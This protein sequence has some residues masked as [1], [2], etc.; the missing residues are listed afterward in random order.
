MQKGTCHL[1]QQKAELKHSHILPAFVFRW[2]KESAGNGHIRHGMEPNKRIQD[3]LKR[4]WLCSSCEDLLNLSE[5]AFATN[6]FHPY[7]EASGK[8]FNYTRWLLPFCVSLSWRV[9]KFYLDETHLNNWDS[10]SLAHVVKAEKVWREFLLEE[11]PHPGS[12]Q[13]HILPLDQIA[14]ATGEL[15]P[16]INRYLMRAVDMDICKGGKTIFTYTKLGRFIVLGFV[17]EPNPNNWRSTKVNANKGLVGPKKYILPRSFWDYLDQKA[18]RMDELLNSVSDKQQSKI[19]GA[20]RKNID[21]YLESDAHQAMLA[22]LSMFG[23]AAFSKRDN[24]KN[25]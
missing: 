12:Y 16:N 4:Y 8:Q 20:F 15:A 6:L 21:R 24:K 19:D 14:S 17:H 9:L 22:D 11:R 18:R 25:R 23:D 5:T 13:Q 10:E 2:L 1:C 7:L 3:G